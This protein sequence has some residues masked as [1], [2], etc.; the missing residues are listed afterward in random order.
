MNMAKTNQGM[1]PERD[2]TLAGL[3]KKE[4]YHFLDFLFSSLQNCETT[5]FCCLS[6]PVCSTLL[7][8][9]TRINIHAF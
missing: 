8:Q 1:G 3:R 5:H 9:Q 4:P 2:P 7:E 6:H